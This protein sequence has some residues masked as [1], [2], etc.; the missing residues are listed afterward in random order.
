[1][2]QSVTPPPSQ[3]ANA[4]I[5][6]LPRR[7]AWAPRTRSRLL[8]PKILAAAVV[9]LLALAYGGREIYLRFTHIYEYDA[10]AT[11]DIVT[12]SSRADGWVVD[13]PALEGMRVK[14]GEV[15]VRID[16]RIAKLKIDSL[17][18]QIE[19]VRAERTRLK[20]ERTLEPEAGR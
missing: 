6:V 3:L 14:A 8:Q 15:V 18:A 17:K 10:R 4:Q 16:D 19:G 1:M 2:D 7:S 11:A 5:G 12:I 20:A 13:M 9:V